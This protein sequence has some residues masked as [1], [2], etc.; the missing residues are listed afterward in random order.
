MGHEVSHFFR[1]K[2][3]EKYRKRRGPQR[4]SPA[5][6]RVSHRVR[7][8]TQVRKGSANGNADFLSRL[9]Q[10]ATEHDR[11]A[12]SRDIPVDDEAIH[13]VRV[14]RLHTSSASV[15]SIGLGGLVP[16]PDSAIP[17]G[18]LLIPTDSRDFRAHG[19][20]MRIDE[21]VLLPGESSP[22]FLLSSIPVMT[23]SAVNRFGLPPISFFAVPFGATLP[24][25]PPLAPTPPSEASVALP[26][27]DL[28]STRARRKTVAAAGAAHPAVDYG[29]E[30]GM[31]PRSSSFRVDPPPRGPS[32]RPPLA[33]V[34]GPPRTLTP[35][36][37]VPIP[38]DRDRA[39]MF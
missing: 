23:A 19:P 38:S 36:P 5:V 16:Q 33:V 11:S 21:F 13:L 39:E 9:P 25:L 22:V 26:P 35:V 32:P 34:P 1:L 12:S 27:S 6:A 37:T 4:A 17:G 24:E 18:L 2:D 8:R 15:P 30:P 20:R 28:I 29:S 7:L 31:V 3:S 14:C 10:P